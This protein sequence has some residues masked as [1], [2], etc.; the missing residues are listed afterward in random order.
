MYENLYK[1]AKENNSDVVKSTDTGF[2]KSGQEKDQAQTNVVNNSTQAGITD[3][4]I[5]STLPTDTA[6]VAE[7]SSASKDALNQS[8]VVANDKTNLVNDTL[9][10]STQTSRQ[11]DNTSVKTNV[12]NQVTTDNHYVGGQHIKIDDAFKDVF[13]KSFTID[14]SLKYKDIAETQFKNNTYQSDPVAKT[15]P[16]DVYNL[17]D[18]QLTRIN[19]YTTDIINNLRHDV[20]IDKTEDYK[21]NTDLM[22]WQQNQT[23]K[24]AELNLWGH[25]AEYMHGAGENI[26]A[27]PIDNITG[28][29]IS[30]LKPSD[31]N[32][33]YDPNAKT[34]TTWSPV[35]AVKTMIYMRLVTI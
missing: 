27:L 28:R 11:L 4:A 24:Q 21:I 12:S 26:G 16:V 31:F 32:F 2:A 10:S 22:K 29:P 3:S 33:T 5:N 20:G 35:I 25:Q 8:Q 9:S 18:S 17:T 7:S 6:N 14:D 13:P 30:E 23:K 34:I 1:V 15:E 19:K